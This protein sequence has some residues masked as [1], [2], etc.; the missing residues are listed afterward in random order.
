MYPATSLI[1]MIASCHVV[2][3]SPSKNSLLKSLYTKSLPAAQIIWMA[4]GYVKVQAS[5]KLRGAMG[6][7]TQGSFLS[8]GSQVILCQVLGP[9]ESRWLPPIVA[10]Q[11]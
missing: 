9:F 5:V 3:L 2:L 6:S 4:E 11:Q 10:R 1:M 8:N 7:I